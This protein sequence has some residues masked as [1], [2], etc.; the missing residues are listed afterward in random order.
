MAMPEEI[1]GLLRS[2]ITFKWSDGHETIYPA[3]QLRLSCRCAACIEEMSGAP[4]LDPAS[5]AENVRAKQIDLVGQYAI[6]IAWSDGHDSGIFN[7]RDLRRNCPC[8]T[9][10]GIRERGGLPGESDAQ[11]RTPDEK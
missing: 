9:C 5:V 10:A 2:K 8:A 6:Q 3:R 4:L 1:V 11:G 7:F